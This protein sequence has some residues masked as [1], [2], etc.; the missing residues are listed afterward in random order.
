MGLPTK[1]QRKAWA[2]W[3]DAWW[4]SGDGPFAVVCPCR[5][6]TIGLYKDED[7]AAASFERQ[8]RIP[9]GDCCDSDTHSLHRL[10]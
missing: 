2:R 1:W 10:D 4:I 7:D 8:Q 9:C 6:L 3:P 5:W